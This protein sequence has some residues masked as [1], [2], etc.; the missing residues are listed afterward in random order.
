MDDTTK[1]LIGEDKTKLLLVALKV[2]LE[3][4]ICLKFVKS[5]EEP[6]VINGSD[7]AL[8]EFI[9]VLK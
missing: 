1:S 4:F 2:I 8:F 3:P 6:E 7:F 9:W 5:A